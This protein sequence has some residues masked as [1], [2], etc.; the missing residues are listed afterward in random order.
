VTTNLE[1]ERKAIS[2]TQIQIV[3]QKAAPSSDRE[4]TIPVALEATDEENDL[5]IYSFDPSAIKK[6]WN[7]FLVKP[8]P[9]E[10]KLPEIGEDVLLTGYF[11]KFPQPFS[12]LGTVS[13][14]TGDKF[15]SGETTFNGAIFADLTAIPGH[16]GAP[17][18][19]LKTE[20]VVGVSTRVLTPDKDRARISISTNSSH[21]KILLG[22]ITKP[23]DTDSNK[24]L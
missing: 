3:V 22:T 23:Q 10:D 9:L 13:M 16:S 21:L 1:K 11:E 24:P 4:F 7:D 5:A 18:F 12:S 6:Q 17:L 15:V 2:E 20:T 8:L 14:I 19:S